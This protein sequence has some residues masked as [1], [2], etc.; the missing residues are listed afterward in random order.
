MT[1]LL[2]MLGITINPW[3]ILGVIAIAT[4]GGTMLYSKGYNNAERKCNV[5][6]LQSQIDTL[7]AD[8]KILEDNL[9]QARTKMK[10]LEDQRKQDE[11][12]NDKLRTDLSK[13][14]A[15][16]HCRLTEPD[17]RRLRN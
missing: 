17:A 16:V 10:E 13:T 2:G 7:K 3:I 1:K 6:K 4:A 14:K 8:K 5:A 15:G 11:Q 9:A 12:E